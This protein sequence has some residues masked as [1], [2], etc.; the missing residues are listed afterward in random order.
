MIKFKPNFRALREAKR[1]TEGRR[2]TLYEIGK[3]AS[4]SPQTLTRWDN[5]DELSEINAAVAAGLMR[6]FGVTLDEL[7]TIVDDKVSA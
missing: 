2:I 3:K 1:R 5:E 7:V 4:V 6:Y